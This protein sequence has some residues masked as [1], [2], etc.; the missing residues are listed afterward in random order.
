M[1]ALPGGTAG[2][3][4]VRLS[5]G[6]EGFVERA[7]GLRRWWAEYCRNNHSWAGPSFVREGLGAGPRASVDVRAATRPRDA[8]QS[9]AAAGP[10]HQCL[11]PG[12]TAPR[13]SLT[14]KR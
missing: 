4:M 10:E 14:Q 12:D 7:Q 3:V 9:V 2:F 11:R 1:E 5:D 6:T 13:R 8:L